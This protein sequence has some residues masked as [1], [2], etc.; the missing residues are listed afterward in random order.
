MRFC[1]F[2]FAVLVFQPV[3][4]GVVEY[5]D[6]AYDSV[7]DKFRNFLG[8]LRSDVTIAVDCT[9]FAVEQLI[10]SDNEEYRQR[11]EQQIYAT[12]DATANTVYASSDYATAQ[13][14]NNNI[15]GAMVHEDIKT[16]SSQLSSSLNN[17]LHDNDVRS[18][19]DMIRNS[20]NGESTHLQEV[21]SYL[22]NKLDNLYPKFKNKPIISNSST[23][24][25]IWSNLQTIH[26]AKHSN[27]TKD[28]KVNEI[29]NVVNNILAIVQKNGTDSAGKAKIN[30]MLNTLAND[31]N[32]SET[33]V[34][35]ELVQTDSSP[36]IEN[37]NDDLSKSESD[38]NM[39][40]Q[41]ELEEE[42]TSRNTV[43]ELV[44]PQ[45][46]ENSNELFS[47]VLSSEFGVDSRAVSALVARSN[48]ARNILKQYKE[49]QSI[50]NKYFD[51]PNYVIGDLAPNNDEYFNDDVFDDFW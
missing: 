39:E 48:E 34:D 22:R 10:L 41:G 49:S 12:D 19:L 47:D 1:L 13:N 9:V 42:N 46:M 2:V 31:I 15:I 23:F 24:E 29:D 43:E 18:K 21:N 30:T 50:I 20:L 36:V 32:A 3:C 11:C 38:E 4:C 17:A 35:S 37:E 7:K 44:D 25:A 16:T 28:V 14:A 8:V 45:T 26:E 40:D 5:V 27:Y 6:E 51:N 33:P